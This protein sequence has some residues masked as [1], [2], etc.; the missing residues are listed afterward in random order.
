[1]LK[2]IFL[3]LILLTFFSSHTQAKSPYFDR[4]VK[5][6]GYNSIQVLQDRIEYK[7]Q[8][9]KT[10][11]RLYKK[12][13]HRDTIEKYSK[14]IFVYPKQ[15]VLKYYEYG[16][17]KGEFKVSTGNSDY[18]TPEG[19]FVVL[20]KEAIAWSAIA[21]KW[22]PYFIGFAE[23]G[24]YGLHALPLDK[25]KNQIYDDSALGKDAA[26]GCVRLSEINA[27][28]LYDWVEVQKTKVFVI[29]K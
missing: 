3:C 17:K 8:T 6:T 29:Y 24:K 10:N 9:V 2:R 25:D 21:N 11:E 19:R 1:M 18:P 27:K 5:A 22:M 16:E 7:R 28:T 12:N 4:L 13:K 14:V 26:G 20:N 15:E 23:R